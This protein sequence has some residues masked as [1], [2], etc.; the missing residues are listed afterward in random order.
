MDILNTPIT[1]MKFADV[2]AFCMLK[3]I[4]GV[5]LE[6]KSDFPKDL[7][8]QFVTFSNTQGG[9]IIIGVEEDPKTGL[10]VKWE[11]IDATTKPID[12]VY[13]VAAN[14]VP[15][16]QF[17][18]VTTDNNNGKVFVLIRIREGAAPPYAT[19]SDPTP[20]VRTGNISTPIRSA[21]REELLQLMTKRDRAQGAREAA[22]EFT[23][24]IFELDVADAER[25]RTKEFAT[26]PNEVYAHQLGIGDMAAIFDI[27]VM[28]YYPNRPL[29]E[30]G[31][32]MPTNP[33][34]AEA[35]QSTPYING[36]RSI[37]GGITSFTWSR[38]MG[39]ISNGQ[40]YLSGLS[41]FALDVLRVQSSV[42]QVNTFAIS[43]IIWH[44]LMIARKVIGRA[45]YNG[46]LSMYASLRGGKGATTLPP[47]ESLFPSDTPGKLR[48]GEYKWAAEADTTV[49]V[50]DAQLAN[51]HVELLK[52][53]CW[54]IGLGEIT[55][56]VIIGYFDK[57]GWYKKRNPAA[58]AN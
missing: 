47:F 38:M 56:D 25:E 13:Q 2:V 12:R 15:F 32:I 9:L 57:R 16:P 6:Y 41:Y 17:D 11:G 35:W 31:D 30:Y 42:R 10:P 45:R 18:V 23:R 48:H 37:P 49:L 20:W 28:P 51:V 27:T 24:Q 50:D 29:L 58:V 46:Q 33:L 3:V 40:I 43:E 5:T 54:D 1:E 53:I 8:K 39:M 22:I 34:L 19:N 55:D 14:V 21:N 36:E 44:E 4:E 7:A 52:Q 26:K